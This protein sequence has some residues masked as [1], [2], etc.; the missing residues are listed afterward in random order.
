MDRPPTTAETKPSRHHNWCFTIALFPPSGESWTEPT[1]L[2]D[3]CTYLVYQVEEGEDGFL[4]YQGYVEFANAKTITAAKKCLNCRWAHLEPRRGTVE[5]A[6]DYCAKPGGLEPI[7]EF[8]R[9]KR[10]GE[11]SDLMYIKDRIEQGATEHDLW[12][13]TFSDMVRYFKGIQRAMI[14]MGPKPKRGPVQIIVFWGDPRAGKSQQAKRL[15][16]STP[17]GYY[18][19]DPTSM[20]WDGYQGEKCV[21][22]D[23]FDPSHHAWTWHQMFGWLDDE[24]VP[25]QY[26]GGY[27]S[28]QFTRL[29]ITT[30]F[31]PV[32]W[33][34]PDQHVTA[35]AWEGRMKE[36][37]SYEK[38]FIGRWIKRDPNPEI[39]EID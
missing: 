10:Q 34:K 30:N 17:G 32:L 37:D 29:I 1:S 18:V 2:P 31:G 25:A 27:L 5:Q 33:F 28:L 8:G 12:V 6:I 26:K 23:D 24:I 16:K 39:M 38:R 4:H 36:N 11:R 19:K 15:A 20:W 35:L 22:M 7:V 9:Y 3:Q 14:V 13:E 21:L